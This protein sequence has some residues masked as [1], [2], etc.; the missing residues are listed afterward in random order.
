VA[1]QVVEQSLDIDFDWIITQLCPVD[2][3]F[4]RMGRLHRHHRPGKRPAG[5]TE[6]LCTV[7]LPEGDDF[8]LHGVIYANTRVL[9]RTAEKLVVAPEGM[10][11]FPKAYRDWIEL[12]YQV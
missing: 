11:V 12:V 7:L 10:I 5:F 3:L 9:W 6:P 2:L 8:G 1:T 4:Q